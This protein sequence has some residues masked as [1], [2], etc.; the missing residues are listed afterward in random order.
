MTDLYDC[1]TS[2]ISIADEDSAKLLTWSKCY[3][4]ANY[5][6]ELPIANDANILE[7]GCGYGRYLIALKE[8][9]YTNCYG[10]DISEQQVSYAI[11]KLNLENI[12]KA[13]ALKWLEGKESKYECILLFDI[14]EHL[15]N[16]DL[17]ELGG[18]LYKALHPG[19]KLIIQAPNGM[20]PL[21]PFLWG[22]LTH[23]RAFT[24][25]SMRQYLRSIGFSNIYF[26]ELGPH[27]FSWKDIFRK[28]LWCMF[29]KPMIMAFM[30]VVNGGLMGGVYTANLKTIAIKENL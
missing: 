4:K 14:L 22:D 25:T 16:D 27:I 1:Y 15:A 20:A 29:Y 8:L 13:D 19:G 7:I 2:T 21:S 30:K 23:K 5:I 12:E 26:S 11:N 18:K 10:I 6:N 9:G 3:F 28:M 24:V 17:M